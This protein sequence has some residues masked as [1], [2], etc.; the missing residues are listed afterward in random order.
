MIQDFLTIAIQNE[1]VEW[2]LQTSPPRLLPMNLLVPL[3]V[4]TQLQIYLQTRPRNRLSKCLN[5]NLRELVNVLMNHLRN[6]LIL[7]SN[8]FP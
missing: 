6:W 4:A 1:N 7:I 5:L 2:L 8:E 3:E